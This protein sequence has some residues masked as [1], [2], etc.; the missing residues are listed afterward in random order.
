MR[1]VIIALSAVF[2]LPLVSMAGDG[3]GK[4]MVAHNLDSNHDQRISKDEF[5]QSFIQM[6][7]SRF[8]LLDLNHDGFIDQKDRKGNSQKKFS[9][10]DV[11]HDGVIS[12]DEFNKSESNKGFRWF[13]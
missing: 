9:K 2:F 1:I 13:R 7:D 6:A 4:R 10:I 8:N 11:N 12:Q 5:R 3:H